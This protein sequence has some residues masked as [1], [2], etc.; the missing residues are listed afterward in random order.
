M[1]IGVKRVIVEEGITEMEAYCLSDFLDMTDLELPDSLQKIG[2]QAFRG[3]RQLKKVKLPSR[4]SEIKN[5]RP[6]PLHS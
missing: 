4:I 1:G 5:Y 3:C 6:L 2:K